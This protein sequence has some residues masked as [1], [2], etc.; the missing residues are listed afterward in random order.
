MKK[1]P[2]HVVN[3]RPEIFKI[4]FWVALK[5]KLRKGTEI[6]K[7]EQEFAKYIGTN[8]AIGVW[9]AR[10]G[11]I[12][13]LNALDLHEGDNIILSS[14]N[15]HIIPE[16]ITKLKLSPIFI[17]IDPDT[18][19][20]DAHQLESKITVRTK[21]IIVT[22]IF[23]VPAD[24]EAILSTARKNRITVIEDCAHALG[25][26]HNG[27]KVGSTGDIGFF[28]FGTGKNMPCF[29]GGMITVND[30]QL[31]EK[32]KKIISSSGY[33]SARE[34]MINILKNSSVYLLAN[35]LIFRLFTFHLIRAFS[36]F[37]RD[38]MELEKE[39]HLPS[40]ID[41]YFNRQSLRLSNIQAAV[42]LNQLKKLDHFN[43][44]R[45]RNSALLTQN[46]KECQDIKLQ[47]TKGGQKPIYSYFYIRAKNRDYLWKHL[48]SKGIDTSKEKLMRDCSS[49]DE[50]KS[51]GK[52]CPV[53]FS[54][55][56][57]ML[58]IP[59]SD[60]LQEADIKYITEAIKD[61]YR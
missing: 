55:I 39:E 15:F 18:Y 24:L 9:Q 48:L 42:G 27:K 8:F 32:I 61:A 30:S 17:D 53:S 59:N 47:K 57:N 10:L 38:I 43:E 37:G 2:R 60:R 50:Y 26:K 49:M 52:V 20:M 11:L 51:F 45:I 21:V 29:G 16:I 44:R 7:F 36:K 46:L 22:H 23:G 41:L 34:I 40:S 35:T 31:F 5:N 28:S 56:N 25:T 13:I 3:L 14:Y 4:L 6:E 1:Y 12:A 19:N 58:E 54:I 33:P